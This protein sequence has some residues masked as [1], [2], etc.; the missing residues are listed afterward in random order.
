MKQVVYEK[1]ETVNIKLCLK[2][3]ISAFLK[4]LRSKGIFMSIT[5][6]IQ[7]FP[8]DILGRIYPT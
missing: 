6:G 1:N 2:S 7:N 8:Q 3:F 4:L 5:F